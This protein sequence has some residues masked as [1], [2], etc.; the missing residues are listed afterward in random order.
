MP[1]TPAQPPAMRARKSSGAEENFRHLPALKRNLHAGAGYRRL[2][3]DAGG[4]IASD[5]FGSEGSE[6]GE[7]TGE[8]AL[9]IELAA[10]VGASG[11][12]RSAG[13]SLQPTRAATPINAGTQRP[14]SLGC[15][16]WPRSNPGRTPTLDAK[17]FGSRELDGRVSP[18]NSRAA[19]A[20]LR[21]LAGRGLA[22]EG[23]WRHLGLV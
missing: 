18:N 10:C 19:V 9:R 3:A 4:E 12:G 22:V 11:V 15:G 5:A 1:C 17:P 8:G 7:D 23:S 16:C 13:L 14:I 21:C 6:A 20:S 2:A